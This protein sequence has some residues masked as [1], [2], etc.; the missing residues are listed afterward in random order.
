MELDTV[1]GQVVTTGNNFAVV[2]HGH[3]EFYDS[4]ISQISK[5]ISS[6]ILGNR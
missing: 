6:Q 1:Q 5:A 4:N 2:V 3:F